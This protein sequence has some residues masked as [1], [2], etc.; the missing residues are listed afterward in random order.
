MVDFKTALAALNTGRISYRNLRTQLQ[1]LLDEKP[2]FAPHL[3]G[4][5]ER[6]NDSGDLAKRHYRGIRKLLLSYCVE[7]DDEQIGEADSDVTQVVRSATRQTKQQDVPPASGAGGETDLPSH[8]GGDSSTEATVLGDDQMQQEATR[9]GAAGAEP[10]ART[11]IMDAAASQALRTGD[12]DKTEII[13]QAASVSDEEKTE[14]TGQAPGAGD[15]DK[16]EITDQATGGATDT[17]AIDIDLAG[18]GVAMETAT[19][20][21]WADDEPAEDYT[22]GSVI[23]QR[24]RLEKVLGVGGMGK[25][26]RALDLLKEEAQDKKPHVAVKLL[27]E[28]FKEHPEAFIALQRESSRQQKLA[29]P[30]IATIYDFDRVGGRGTPVYITMELMEGLELKEHIKKNI[31]PSGGIPFDDAYTII[32]QLGAGLTYAHERGLVHSDFKP[33]NAFLCNDGTVKTLDFGIA[34]AVKNPVTGEQEK[35]LFDASKL[36]AL[37][38]AYA[39]LEMLEGAEPDTRDDTYA[40]GCTAYE[41]LTGK[42]PFNKRPAN[43]AARE[44]MVPPYIKTLNRKQNRALRQAV[45]FQR[46]DRSPSVA[47]FVEELAGK[48]TF[49]RSPFFIAAMVLLVIGLVLINPALS[50]QHQQKMKQLVVEINEAGDSET[51]YSYLAEIRKLENPQDRLFVADEAQM[52]LHDYFAQRIRDLLGTRDAEGNY[53]FPNAQA[54]LGEV[55][56]FYPDSQFL[57]EQETEIENRRQQFIADQ[58]GL[59]IDALSDSSKLRNIIDILARIRRVAPQH[60]LLSDLRPVV[61]CS[62]LAKAAYREG[63][64]TGAANYVKIG[65]E[66]VPDDQRLLDLRDGINAAIKVGDLERR[67]SEAQPA[68]SSLSDYA[69]LVPQLEELSN[70]APNSQ[71]LQTLTASVRPLVS[72]ELRT[73][74]ESGNRQSADAAL[75]SYGKLFS[76]LN[77]SREVGALLF[78]H[79]EPTEKKEMIDRIAMRDINTIQLGLQTPDIVHPAWEANLLQNVRQMEALATQAPEY[80]AQLQGFRAS[81]SALYLDQAHNFLEQRRIDR[82]ESLV[83][84]AERF[85]PG[86]ADILSA[87]QELAAA[88]AE[89][90]RRIRVSGNKG[91]LLTLTRGDR[92]E[93]AMR[94]YADLQQDL[95]P[96]DIY[97]TTTA[98]TMLADS[99]GRVARVHAEA[100]D[101]PAAM[102]AA[103]RGYEIQP[104][105]DLLNS[106]GNEYEA[107]V[108]IASLNRLF[109]DDT[110]IA[111][112]GDVRVKVEH[113]RNSAAAGRAAEFTKEAVDLLVKKIN[114]LRTRNETA[115]SV[116]AK[117][118]AELF[119]SSLA[120]G[121]LEE[122]LQLKPWNQFTASRDLLSEGALTRAQTLREQ[123]QSE[124]AGHPQ[125]ET[126]VKNLE[127]KIQEAENVYNLYQQDKEEA[128]EDYIKL[129]ALRNFLV[130]AQ[131][132]WTDNPTYSQE[133]Q[134]LDELIAQHRPKPKPRIRV[135][136]VDISEIAQNALA[137]TEWQPVVSD[138]ECTTRLA[139]H[140]RRAKAICFDMIHRNA[141]GPLM[142]VVPANGEGGGEKSFAIGKYEVSVG[143]WSKYCLLSGTCQPI[144]DQ[145]KNEPITGI[146]LAD[147]RQYASWLSER[148]G[149]TYRLP[150]KDEWE[151]AAFSAGKQPRKDFNCRVSLGDKLIKGTGTIS[152]KSGRSNAWGMKNYIGNVQE[153]VTAAGGRSVVRGGAYSDAHSK[154]DIS[155]ERDHNGEGDE[156][157]GFRILREE[158]GAA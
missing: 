147:A 27:N 75:E 148:T 125:Y 90:E 12:E 55:A 127:R 116:I 109:R 63:L 42:H 138:A 48:A 5:L 112:P 117:L 145:D 45:A 93:E 50:Y 137:S 139:G 113:I 43:K 17:G 10:D 143:D 142:I 131:Q 26:Y 21:G 69:A 102:E 104:T 23:K 72:A 121:Q 57:K 60:A 101:Y 83:D 34:R 36:G 28:S 154:C 123:A 156:V 98:T 119:P 153:W 59:F 136:E 95:P 67:L 73:V 68:L 3:V 31:R 38:P 99:F 39:S 37:T 132:L 107:E 9:V 129:S 8:W 18:G 44:G 70:L 25:V 15:M 122:S 82:A 108:N 74:L 150:N 71:V 120:L 96:D 110:V 80:A 62:D 47:H 56:E 124:Y 65:L 32:R 128:G 103:R 2:E 141:R 130:R 58:N 133:L 79:L 106:L 11:E 77:F 158:I 33:G 91:D 151:Y 4:V 92:I 40:L 135:A 152:V 35:T 61:A 100:E 64:Y 146:S 85:A 16:T 84:K 149:K 22:E 157:T 97:L 118:A 87:R 66:I 54:V 114:T 13:D 49:Y 41:L 20:G 111:L 52:T 144:K 6:I 24:F 134:A 78:A 51:L 86:N 88:H 29:H 105:N 126:F 89:E 76:L 155:L 94:K 140:G 30:N 46:R 7:V 1:A 81:I 53:D 14:I 115:A 19:A